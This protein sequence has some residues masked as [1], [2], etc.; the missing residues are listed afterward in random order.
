MLMLLKTHERTLKIE[1]QH[2][3]GY[4]SKKSVNHS[5]HS[6]WLS[7]FNIIKGLFCVTHYGASVSSAQLIY[8]ISPWGWLNLWHLISHNG[9]HG[10]VDVDAIGCR[11]WGV[12]PCLSPFFFSFGLHE[13]PH[14]TPP[15]LF[16]MVHPVELLHHHDSNS[17]V[18]FHQAICHRLEYCHSCRTCDHRDANL[19]V[20]VFNIGC[21]SQRWS[22]LATCNKRG[23]MIKRKKVKELEKEKKYESKERE[24]RRNKE[25]KVRVRSFIVLS[26]LNRF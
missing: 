20:F 18:A 24:E 19:S 9:W 23:E 16:F 26:W 8:F 7:K 4:A 12:I 21:P 14:P 10:L 15:L 25:S 11:R 22:F 3:L 1:I 2:V 6:D 5:K 17:T 13:S